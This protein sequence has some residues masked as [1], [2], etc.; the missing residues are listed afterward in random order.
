MPELAQGDF[1]D[2]LLDGQ[3]RL[4]SLFASLKGITLQI[5][6]ILAGNLPTYDLPID[7]FEKFIKD[8]GQFNA[9]R[10]YIKAILCIYSDLEPKSFSDHSTV[11]ISNYWLKQA[12]SKN[13]HHF[14]RYNDNSF[15]RRFKHFW[16]MG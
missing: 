8:N 14:T 5:D 7:T 16:Y 11:N 1:I 12:N 15:N 2:Y 6:Q 4:T 10:S 9:A 13:Y 3:Q